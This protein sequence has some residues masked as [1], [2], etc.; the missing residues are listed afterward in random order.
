MIAK[1]FRKMLCIV[2]LHEWIEYK[3]YFDYE[4]EPE[5]FMY[6]RQCRNCLIKQERHPRD[7]KWHKE[8]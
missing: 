2:G 6:R 3:R 1:L 8:N 7:V 4:G 5:D